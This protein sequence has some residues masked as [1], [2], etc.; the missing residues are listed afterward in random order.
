MMNR[1]ETWY[2]RPTIRIRVIS[3]LDQL[4]FFDFR[5][6]RRYSVL[7]AIMAWSVPDNTLEIQFLAPN[8]AWPAGGAFRDTRDKVMRCENL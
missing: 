6:L 5:G 2:C 7:L 8:Q 1:G 3:M 4:S